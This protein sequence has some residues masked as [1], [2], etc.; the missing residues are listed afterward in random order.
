MAQTPHPSPNATTA[1]LYP[2][3]ISAAN[4]V[5]S[6]KQIANQYWE[7]LQNHFDSRV[8]ATGIE[9]HDYRPTDVIVTTFPKS[10]TTVMQHI[11]YQI[12]A[13]SGG[14]PSF[15]RTGQHFPDLYIVSPW[16]DYIPQIGLPVTEMNPRV[17][18]THSPVSKFPNDAA[19]H[20]VVVRN[21]SSYPASFLDF[22]FEAVVPEAVNAP[23]NV[24][25]AI[26]NQ[27]AVS[28]LTTPLQPVPGSDDPTPV[29]GKWHSFVVNS[30]FPL[31]ENVL[32]VFYETLV[33]DF[34]GTVKNIAN[35][36]GCKLSDDAVEE[37]A[38]RCERSAMA[39]DPRFFC[40]IE[41][42]AFGMDKLVAKAKNVH[43]SGYKRFKISSE[44]V[45]ILCD[46]NLKAFGVRTY[47]EFKEMV[48]KKQWEMFRR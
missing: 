7:K 37:V 12:A 25:A 1:T 48:S 31:R 9:Q 17:F 41:T 36:M 27:C 16:L 32:I 18:K 14:G 39:R 4:D 11:S 24:R 6:V 45:D 33:S 44:Q 19:K 40:K 3:N 35:F 8:K 13:L 38:R 30:V 46:M 34:H 21:P 26:F 23:E 10:G 22:I 28:H 29:L 15:D 2:C 42:K 47:E 20:I 43:N 5:S